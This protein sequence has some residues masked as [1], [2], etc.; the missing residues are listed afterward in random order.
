MAWDQ[1]LKKISLNNTTG[2]K[3][4]NGQSHSNNYKYNDGFR[5]HS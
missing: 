5:V 2:L 3:G 4:A 1:Q